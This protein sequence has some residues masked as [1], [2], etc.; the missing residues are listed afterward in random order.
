MPKFFVFSDCHGNKDALEQAINN[1]GFDKHNSNHWLVGLG[2]YFDRFRQPQE[3]MD[4]LNSI[5]R[6]ILCLGNHEEL[7]LDCIERGYPLSHDWHNGTAQTIIDLAPN[8]ETFEVA[9]VVAYE[10]VKDFIDSM[11]NYVEFKKHIGVHSFVPLECN[12]NLPTHYTRNRKFEKKS[13]WRSATNKEWQLARWGNPYDLAQQGFLPDKTL[14]FGHFHTSY[15]RAKY[16]GKEEFGSEA[17][18]SIYCGEGYIALDGCVTAYNG[19]INI[20]VLED[21]FIDGEC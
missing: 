20:L 1:A 11:V 21:D 13:D 14:I 15:P 6:K 9:C 17:D 4:Y 12:D 5:E 10:K 2:D 19:R 7:L 3:V 18:F 8:A 16:E